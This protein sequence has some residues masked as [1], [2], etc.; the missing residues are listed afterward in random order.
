MD[1][2]LHNVE[3]PTVFHSMPVESVLGIAFWPSA[4]W[5]NYIFLGAL[6]GFSR[7]WMLGGGIGNGLRS[8]TCSLPAGQLGLQTLICLQ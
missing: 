6:A 5:K 8:G 2:L 1:N 3:N 4:L 7:E